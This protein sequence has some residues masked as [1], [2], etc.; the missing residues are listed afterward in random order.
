MTQLIFHDFDYVDENNN[1]AQGN[2]DMSFNFRNRNAPLKRNKSN[3]KKK[4]KRRSSNSGSPHMKHGFASINDKSHQTLHPDM[5]GGGNAPTFYDVA[6]HDAS[7]REGSNSFARLNRHGNHSGKLFRG[8]DDYEHRH[9]LDPEHS[10]INKNVLRARRRVKERRDREARVK[11][12]VPFIHFFNKKGH[13]RRK[14]K[15]HQTEAPLPFFG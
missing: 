14:L 11:G 7:S 4:S 6:H 9:Y 3:K 5:M 15:K 13:G 12:E 10:N 1:P 2:F 8:D